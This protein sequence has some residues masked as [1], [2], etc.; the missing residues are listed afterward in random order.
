M[1]IAME[2]RILG[3]DVSGNPFKWLYAEDAVH[4]YVT[5]KV[6][7]DLGEE[8]KVFRGGYQNSGD[9]SIVSVKS[10][11]AVKGETKVFSRANVTSHGQ[12]LLFRRDHF[13]CAYCGQ[14]HEP[15]HLSR[16]HVI[17]KS[18]GGSNSWENSV[19]ACRECNMKKSN[20]LPEEANMMLIYTPYRPCRWEHFIL[21]NRNVIGDQMDYLKAKLPKHSRHN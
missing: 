8:F 11:I 6:I 13:I 21:E 7:W 20:K 1:F 4:Y 18:R 15:E 17:P 3:L 5:N 9:R 16:D 10:I 14:K 2:K 19:T 12:N